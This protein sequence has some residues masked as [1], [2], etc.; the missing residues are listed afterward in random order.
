MLRALCLIIEGHS[1]IGI[2]IYGLRVAVD[3]RGPRF[4]PVL[5]G[6]VLD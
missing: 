2:L 6:A 3:F 5:A 4:C 1:L